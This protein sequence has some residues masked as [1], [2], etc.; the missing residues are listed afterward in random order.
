MGDSLPYIDNLLPLGI[1]REILQVDGPHHGAYDRN[2]LF[3]DGTFDNLVK[4]KELRLALNKKR[5]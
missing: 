5:C 3:G 2:G 1:A 4:N